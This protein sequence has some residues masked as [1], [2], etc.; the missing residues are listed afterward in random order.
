MLTNLV[1]SGKVVTTPKRA[2]VLKAEAD[3][4]FCKL[5]DISTRYSDE[6]D[7]KREVIRYVK[8]TIYGEEEWKK[9]VSI[10]LPKYL[11]SS[12]K[13]GFVENYKIWFRKWDAVEKIMVKL[14]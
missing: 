4:F 6:S 5:L 7:W 3:S 2:K 13:S 11:D 10:Y 1:R 14:A 9:V 12:K 8:S